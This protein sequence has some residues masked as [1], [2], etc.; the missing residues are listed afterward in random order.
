MPSEFG[1]WRAATQLFIRWWKRG[2][3]QRPA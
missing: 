3:W 2:V 1:S